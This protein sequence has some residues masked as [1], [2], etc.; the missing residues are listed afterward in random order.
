MFIIINLLIRNCIFIPC[1]LNY[2]ENK[3]KY[4]IKHM[5]IFKQQNT[6]SFC[7][8]ICCSVICCYQAF[9]FRCFAIILK[10]KISHL[11]LCI[12]IINIYWIF[13]PLS[14]FIAFMFKKL[15]HQ[16]NFKVSTLSF[17]TQK[18]IDF[19]L[20]QNISSI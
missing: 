2:L 12:S 8:V 3:V 14:L 6:S 11:K 7:S 18:I 4:L 13:L 20:D 19:C 5:K 1:C 15:H 17:H 16:H 10:F 9:F